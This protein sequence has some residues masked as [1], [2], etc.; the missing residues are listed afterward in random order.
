[1]VAAPGEDA[2]PAAALI[3][4]CRSHTVA[5]VRLLQS[6]LKLPQ[7]QPNPYR[8]LDKHPTDQHDRHAECR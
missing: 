4:C 1:M 3:G 5:I 8:A 6:E 7:L 2:W